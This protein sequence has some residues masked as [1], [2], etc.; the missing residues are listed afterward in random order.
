MGK[1]QSIWERSWTD[2]F[3]FQE[4][5]LQSGPA[6]GN[7]RP[8]WVDTELTDRGG[9]PKKLQCRRFNLFLLPWFHFDA[10]GFSFTVTS[11]F[12]QQIF[13]EVG[14]VPGTI[15]APGTPAMKMTWNLLHVGH[16]W[17]ISLTFLW[18]IALPA[19]P[20]RSPPSCRWDS[21]LLSPTNTSFG[22]SPFCPAH[23]SVLPTS[24]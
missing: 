17:G 19:G 8:Q 21:E 22:F 20:A 23:P 13:S 14:Y 1:E 11:L 9:V 2:V 16:F 7:V 24:L 10:K 12:I 18:W 5:M 15:Q 3:I 6:A 4:R